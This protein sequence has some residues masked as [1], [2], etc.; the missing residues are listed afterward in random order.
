V[1]K[2]EETVV[3]HTLKNA[4]EAQALGAWLESRSVEHL[5]E[6][7]IDSAY[8]G[9]YVPTRGWGVVRVF[10]RDREAARAAVAEFLKDHPSEDASPS[11]EPE[12]N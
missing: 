5:I 10:L 6:S 3:V 8:D 4:F 7:F 9:V 2:P 12:E 1:A 11:G